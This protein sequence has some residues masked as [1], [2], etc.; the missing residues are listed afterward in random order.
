MY[1]CISYHQTE[2]IFCVYISRYTQRYYSRYIHCIIVISDCS[3][4]G[5]LCHL[6]SFFLAHYIG[7]HK[8]N[9]RESLYGTSMRITPMQLYIAIAT[10]L[11]VCENCHVVIRM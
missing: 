1:I 2:A 10:A 5:V 9:H 4:G 7:K 11:H 3:V 8:G 6:Y